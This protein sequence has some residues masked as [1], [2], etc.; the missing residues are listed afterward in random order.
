MASTVSTTGQLEYMLYM[1]SVQLSMRLVKNH[2]TKV[3]TLRRALVRLQR[4]YDALYKGNCSM[5]Q[6]HDAR[7]CHERM[8]RLMGVV[9]MY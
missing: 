8:Q 1:E 5:L 3:T 6:W 7:L 2:K 9:Y 4:R